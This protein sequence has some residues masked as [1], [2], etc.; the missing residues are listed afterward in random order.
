MVDAPEVRPASCPARDEV[1]RQYA[2]YYYGDKRIRHSP[3]RL[4]EFAA[5]ARQHGLLTFANY[6]DQLAER[7]E[8]ED[9]QQ[10]LQSIAE[11][12][13]HRSYLRNDYR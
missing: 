8:Y 7:A 4:M 2:A 5:T 1:L 9:E 6:F 3:T 10:M 11:A 13:S 12:E